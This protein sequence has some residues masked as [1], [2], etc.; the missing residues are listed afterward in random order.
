LVKIF[1]IQSIRFF[2]LLPVGSSDAKVKGLLVYTPSKFTEW[3]IQC[4]L[5][6]SKQTCG[7]HFNPNK[8][9][10]PLKLAMYNDRAKFPSTGGYVWISDCCPDRFVSVF[11]GSLFE[12][13]N[14]PPTTILKLIY[15]WACQTN[16]QNVMS[17]V[18]TEAPYI[19]GFFRCGLPVLVVDYGH[20]R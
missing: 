16:P 5:L 18:K 9:P 15:H 6:R 7:T 1:I 8:T 12:G 4:G 13:Q 3:L 14:H 19:N 11:R 2:C 10:I 17:W 20:E